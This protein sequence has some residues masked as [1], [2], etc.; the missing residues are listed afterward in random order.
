MVTP[1]IGRMLFIGDAAAYGE[2]LVPGAIRCG[3]YAAKAVQEELSGKNGFRQFQQFWSSNFEYVTN[4]QK[5]QDYT[6]ILR[7]FRSLEDEDVDFLFKLSEEKGPIE[8]KGDVLASNEFTKA[9]SLIDYFLAFPQ[10]QGELR[11]K[12]QAVRGNGSPS[13]EPV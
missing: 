6:K 4:P 9:N 12:L 8:E 10:V 1:S 2:T 11:T 13:K 7:L 5:Q 3:Y